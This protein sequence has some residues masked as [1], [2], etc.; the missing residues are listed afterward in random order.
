MGSPAAPILQ[1]GVLES[2]LVPADAPVESQQHLM[3]EAE[4]CK[5]RFMGFVPV[6]P[7]RFSP[8]SLSHLPINYLHLSLVAGPD[9][10][11]PN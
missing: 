4:T 2:A 10:L 9:S 5:D 11:G 7:C 8:V 1:E 6:V 3:P